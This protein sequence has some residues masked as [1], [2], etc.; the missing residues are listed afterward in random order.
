[1]TQETKQGRKPDFKG[2]GVAV[3]VNE[4]D[5]NKYLSIKLLGSINVAAWKNEP[6]EKKE[7]P[8]I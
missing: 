1:M 7:V 4:K 8:S 5:G 3:W 6:K 2:D